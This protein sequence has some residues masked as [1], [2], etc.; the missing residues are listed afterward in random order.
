MLDFEELLDRLNRRDAEQRDQWTRQLGV[1][2]PPG[3]N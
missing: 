1:V 3:L 2:L